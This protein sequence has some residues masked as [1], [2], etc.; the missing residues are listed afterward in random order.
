MTR[1]EMLD[2]Y[3]ATALEDT[4]RVAR[5]NNDDD[6]GEDP[7][8]LVVA[9]NGDMVIYVAA[10]SDESDAEEFFGAIR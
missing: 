9:Y 4:T 3:I 6:P 7:T 10:F 1:N 5:V 8:F 2:S